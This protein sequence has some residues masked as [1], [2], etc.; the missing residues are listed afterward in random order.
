M[1]SLGRTPGGGG[2]HG[3]G[4]LPPHVSR[5]IPG[6]WAHPASHNGWAWLSYAAKCWWAEQRRRDQEEG[7]SWLATLCLLNCTVGVNEWLRSGSVRV[8]EVYSTEATCP[9]RGYFSFPG[10]T[11]SPPVEQCLPLS[12]RCHVELSPATPGKLQAERRAER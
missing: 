11:F 9:S 4:P 2:A 6:H 7:R 3:V 5:S 12:T 1:C 8:P 10:A